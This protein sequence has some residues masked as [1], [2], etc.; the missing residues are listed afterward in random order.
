MSDPPTHKASTFAEATAPQ[1]SATSEWPAVTDCQL[2]IADLD[3]KQWS[4]DL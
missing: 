1:D 2:P 4:W 3:Q